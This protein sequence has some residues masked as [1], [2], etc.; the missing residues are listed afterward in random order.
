M[1]T[2]SRLLVVAAGLMPIAAPCADDSLASFGGLTALTLK[3]EGVTLYYLPAI[4][5]VLT[6]PHP[7][8][9]AYDEAGVYASRPLRTRIVPTEAQDFVVDCDSGGSW[10]P[11]CT[12][13][14]E[15]RGELKEV[16]GIRG[17]RFIFPGNGSIYVDGHND[18]MFN[19][20]RKFEW[21][22]GTF[23]E[24]KQPFLYVGLRSTA[25]KEL[26]LF[27]T[28]ALAGNVVAK[29]P[30]NSPVEV[31]VA[32]HPPK[33]DEQPRL[34]LVR[35]SFGLTGWARIEQGDVE[36]IEYAGD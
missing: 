21:R 34:Y 18:N 19:V 8:A 32:K 30:A 26:T 12:I 7:D 29:I 23:V 5:K 1:S 6:A 4:S 3:N 9:H 35:T 13:M 20:R 2:L 28:D 17:L 15:D 14:R 33:P 31:L 22:D 25:K 36:G 10:D 16:V 27:E 11:G 24:V